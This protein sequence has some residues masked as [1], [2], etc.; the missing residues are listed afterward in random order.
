MWERLKC[1]YNGVCYKHRCPIIT[2]D[3]G[4]K[5]CPIHERE[6]ELYRISLMSSVARK[7]SIKQ[8]NR[9]HSQLAIDEIELVPKEVE[10]TE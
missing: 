2:I 7:E 9:D 5:I 4:I 10:E 3:G 1:W 6:R 8:W